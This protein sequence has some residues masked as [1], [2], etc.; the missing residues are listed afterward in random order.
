[1]TFQGP[2]KPGNKN[3]KI[4]GGRKPDIGRSREV[5]RGK[6]PPPKDSFPKNEKKG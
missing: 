5:E 6:P 3:R 2:Q 4:E 1:M